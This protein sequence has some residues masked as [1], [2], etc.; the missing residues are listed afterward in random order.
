MLHLSL[1]ENLGRLAR[2]CKATAAARMMLSI[3]TSPSLCNA[4]FHVPNQLRMAASSWDF[5]TCVQ[6]SM[7]TIPHGGC[8][9]GVRASALK[10]DPGRD[11]TTKN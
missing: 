7:Y 5:L 4:H 3:P 11:T 9:N 10:V 6:T 1:A 8:T 2:P